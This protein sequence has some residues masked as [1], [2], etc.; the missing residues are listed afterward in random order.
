MYS[1]FRPVRFSN[2]NSENL[3]GSGPT[4]DHISYFFLMSSLKLSM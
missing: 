1:Q 4:R 3:K 2:S